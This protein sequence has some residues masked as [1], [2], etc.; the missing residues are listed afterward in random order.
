MTVTLTE[1]AYAGK[2]GHEQSLPALSLSLSLSLLLTLTHYLSY[3]FYI[4]SIPFPLSLV[5]PLS[6]YPAFSRSCTASN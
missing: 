2:S 5:K 1:L 3:M 6:F 4:L